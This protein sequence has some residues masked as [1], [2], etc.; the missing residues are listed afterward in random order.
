MSPTLESRRNGVLEGSH[1]EE[2]AH[3]SS[4]PR[5]QSLAGPAV[6]QNYPNKPITMIVPFAAGGPTDIVARIVAEPMSRTLGQQ[7]VVENV[8]GAGG[9]TGITRGAGAAPDGYT[10]MMGHMGTHG[11]APAL[12]PNLKYNPAADFAPIGMAAGTPIVIVATKKHP[13]N[14]LQEF[15]AW[16][17]KQG[18][19]ANHAHAGVGSV[20]HFDRHSA[21]L[22]HR[23]EADL[24]PLHGDGPGAQRPRVRPGRLHDR[25]DRQRGRSGQ[26]RFHQGLRHCDAC[27]LARAAE[28]ADHQGGGPAQ[29]RSQRLERDLR[30][31]GHAGGHRQAVERR[32]RQG[33][34]RH[35]RAQA[36]RRSRRAS[37]PRAPSA[38]PQPCRSWS[39]AKWRAGRQFSRKRWRRPRSKPLAS[40]IYR[41]RAPARR[42]FVWRA[43]S[44]SIKSRR[45][46]TS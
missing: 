17:K 21:Q 43:A 1:Y 41:R 33:A 36:P 13:A 25:P 38:A 12:Y 5:L 14:N 35:E 27:A 2:D 46:E 22:D 10:I 39:R 3:C 6:A 45:E 24:H 18:D 23:H 31:Q 29:L 4:R 11:A 44:V 26:R 40:E 28:R 16:A 42:F 15:I 30:A 34:R 32:A 8:A 19:K 37:F 20:S 9:T 7:I